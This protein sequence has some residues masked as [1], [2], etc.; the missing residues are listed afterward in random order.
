MTTPE[1]FIITR[2]IKAP[3][4]LVWAMWSDPVHLPHWWGPKGLS[5]RVCKLEFKPGGLFHYAMGTPDGKEMWGRFIYGEIVEPEKIVFINSFADAEGQ[6]IRAPF[7]PVWPLEVHNTLTLE[8]RAGQTVLT[9][10][11][12]PL[13]ASELEM[14]TFKAMHPSMQ[15]GFGGTFDQLDAYL[16]T[17][18]EK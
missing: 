17:L 6:V 5:L 15:M 3:R 16:G 11:G 18:G 8:E 13:K 14:Q 2:T 1:D 10:R 7:S 9:L 12:H 4:A